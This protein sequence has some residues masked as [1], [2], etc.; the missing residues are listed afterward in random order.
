VGIAAQHAAGIPAVRSVR[1]LTHRFELSF[2]EQLMQADETYDGYS[3]EHIRRAVRSGA[4]R[5]MRFI[6]LSPVT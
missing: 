3:D 1:L 2:D 4:F 6:I 5:R